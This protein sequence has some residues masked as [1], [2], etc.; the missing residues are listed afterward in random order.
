MNQKGFS[1]III[2]ILILL[3]LGFLYVLKQI[4]FTK[5]GSLPNLITQSNQPSNPLNRVYYTWKT[6]LN[7]ID[8]GSGEKGKIDL[9]M[10]LPTSYGG[11][12]GVQDNPDHYAQL[13]AD[14]K[15]MVITK[16]NNLWKIDTDG[17]NLKQLTTEGT[18]TNETSCP[19]KID[20]FL[21]SPD[22]QKVYFS[23]TGDYYFKGGANRNN[24]GKAC[25]PTFKND[26]QEWIVDVGGKKQEIKR[27]HTQYSG[28]AIGWAPDSKS[29]YYSYSGNPG[30]FVKYEV[31]SKTI[32]DLLKNEVGIIR[33]N[34]DGT[35][36]FYTD[37][38][39]FSTG[40]KLHI[41]DK[42]FKELGVQSVIT[43][44]PEGEAL[45]KDKYDWE[46]WNPQQLSSD[47]K[48]L[49]LI[50]T[51]QVHPP[52]EKGDNYWENRHLEQKSEVYLLDTD[53]NQK[54][55]LEEVTV[56][57]ATQI[58]WSVDGSKLIYHV[59]MTQ[60]DHTDPHQNQLYV[61]DLKNKKGK[62]LIDFEQQSQK[63]NEFY[64][65]FLY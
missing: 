39:A 64:D 1:P 13:S 46:F 48:Y 45:L 23:I 10:E 9:N 22:S 56:D 49:V 51:P 42:D 7:F 17:N 35:R 15:Y 24:E 57:K 65:Y 40:T 2:L 50:R 19:V 37:G 30:K 32:S 33:W 4:N 59:Y 6:N 62:S 47:G 63:T 60:L 20:Q 3:L 5:N 28:K 43:G 16:D 34:K 41:I 44:V 53:N 14:K 26:V 55:K 61:Y 21:I 29:I 52:I 18:S 12:S 25:A 31:E 54:I 11:Y 38:P 8:A 58:S 27:E 36:G